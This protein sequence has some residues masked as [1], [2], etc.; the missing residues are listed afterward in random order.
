[1]MANA[2]PCSA[3]ASFDLV[4]SHKHC[5][6]FRGEDTVLG[7]LVG[8][9]SPLSKKR[10]TRLHKAID[11]FQVIGINPSRS[12]I[13]SPSIC[14][15]PFNAQLLTC[16]NPGM[17]R[18]STDIVGGISPSSRSASSTLP[19]LAREIMPVVSKKCPSRRKS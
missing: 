8:L 9:S 11:Q 1:M 2:S 6:A 14:A 16:V 13:S 5:R 18:L 4:E 7:G 15:L 17:K 12:A 19:S 10:H 3:I